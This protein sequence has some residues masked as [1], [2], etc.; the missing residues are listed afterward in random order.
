MKKSAARKPAPAVAPLHLD[1]DE[2]L[3]LRALL[4]PRLAAWGFDT[5][6]ALT[7][8]LSAEDIESTVTGLLDEAVLEANLPM[9]VDYAALPVELAESRAIARERHGEIQELRSQNALLSAALAESDALRETARREVA[10]LSDLLAK[11]NEQLNQALDSPRPLA[12]AT[13]ENLTSPASVVAA[14]KADQ[15]LAASG[16]RLE[17]ALK[18]GRMYFDSVG[19]FELQKRPRPGG[20]TDYQPVAVGANAEGNWRRFLRVTRDSRGFG[21]N[22]TPI[23]PTGAETSRPVVGGVIRGLGAL[24]SL[25]NLGKGN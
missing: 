2:S 21:W 8:V 13:P 7:I 4:G 1:P 3:Y 22:E 11:S 10:R 25:L 19:R 5:S 24:D 15:E 9:T 12:S 23:A 18:E 16:R 20:G 17:A 6:L 14:S